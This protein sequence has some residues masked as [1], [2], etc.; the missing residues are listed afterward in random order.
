MRKVLME[1]WD[2]IGVNGIDDAS[3]EYDSY[4]ARVYVMLMDERASVEEIAEYLFDIASNH[5]GLSDHAFLRQVSDEAA[6]I[7]F[8]LRGE[9]ELN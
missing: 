1:H 7:A 2:P 8:S 4:A 9:F 5:M 6:K 3:D